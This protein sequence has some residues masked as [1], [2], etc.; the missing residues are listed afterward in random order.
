MY[1]KQYSSSE[2]EGRQDCEELG[3]EYSFADLS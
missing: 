1:Y 2:V 3:E